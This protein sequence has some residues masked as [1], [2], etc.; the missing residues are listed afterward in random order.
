MHDLRKFYIT[1]VCRSKL[2]FAGERLSKRHQ[3]LIADDQT[4]TPYCYKVSS[5][6]AFNDIRSKNNAIRDKAY[7]IS[8]LCQR[9]RDLWLFTYL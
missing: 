2:L 8:T 7:L 9:I 1:A 6:H 5:L 4:I 3:T